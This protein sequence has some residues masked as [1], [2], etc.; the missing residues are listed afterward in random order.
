MGYRVLIGVDDTLPRERI[1]E[2]VASVRERLGQDA[3]Y[4]NRE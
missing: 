2:R 4:T 3:D 1:V